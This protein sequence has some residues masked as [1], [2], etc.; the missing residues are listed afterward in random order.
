MTLK[1][2]V[3]PDL[4]INACLDDLAQALEAGHVILSASTGSGKT[5][6]VPISLLDQPWLAG[7]KII[8]LEP[9]RPAAR[10]AAHRMAY[11][12]GEKTGNTVGYQVRFDRQI[13][14][15]TRVEV[16]TEGLLLK[17]LQ[18]DPELSGVGLIIFDE[19]HERS[20]VAD[21][22]LALCID[23]C[24][25][26]RDDLRLLIMSATLD[27]AGLTQL[28]NA[29]TITAP[30]YLHPVTV[31]YARH[32]LPL[33][34]AVEACLPLVDQALDLVEADVLVFLPG[35]KEISQMQALAEEKWHSRCEIFSLYGDLSIE[36]QDQVLNPTHKK[37]RRLILAT[38]IAE[39]SLTIEGV[40]AVV[41]SGRVRK[42]LFQPTNGL[43]RLQMHWVSKA[44]ASQRTGRAGRLGPGLCFRAWTESFHQR[45]E[46][47]IVPEI[48]NADLA[49]TV[50]EVAAWGVNDPVQLN[51]FD[52]P[53]EAH[54]QQARDLLIRLDGIDRQGHITGQGREMSVLPVHPRLAHMLMQAVSKEDKQMVADIAALLTERDPL[55]RHP[56]S[57][58]SVDLTLRL[59][60]LTQWRQRQS[61][62][63]ADKKTLQ[64]LDR[65]SKQFLK[66]LPDK[67]NAHQDADLSVGAYLAMAYPDRVAKRR[68]NATDYLM[69]NGRGVLLPQD[70][71]LVTA[72]YLVIANLDAGKRDSRAWL[73]ATIKYCEIENLFEQQIQQQRIT[74]WDDH[75]QKVVARERSSLGQ[76]IL[77][78]HQVPLKKDDPVID[79]LLEQVSKQ[80]LCLFGDIGK[81]DSLRARIQTL[82]KLKS[83]G[84]WPDVSETGLLANLDTWLVPWLDNITSLKQLRQIDLVSVF[85]S[86]LGWEKRQRLNEL[87]PETYLTPAGT[88]RKI[89]YD[90][91]EQPVLSV[92][93]QEMLGIAD[94][95][96][97]AAGELPLVIHLLSPSGRPLQVTGDLA[98]FWQGAY[99]EVKKEM[100][101]RYPKHYWPDDPTSAQATRFT[102]RHLKK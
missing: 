88:Q 71:A 35:R 49:A 57:M 83:F 59:S 41:D 22:S 101:G 100:R 36:K 87:L 73:A 78:E 95:H 25:G 98:G 76:I 31:H 63:D 48:L 17:R 51:W 77:T 68:S 14:S 89:N 79:T 91:T 6:V 11:L 50:L 60:A 97:I 19:F 84:D 80:G 7:K 53:P 39:T 45:L 85:E 86:W 29:K 38:D 56:G 32:D 40:E 5:T 15:D 28:L 102:K 52:F 37:Q 20:L 4:P 13:S 47:F 1:H 58:P 3:P 16:L 27:T 33:N 44:S 65:L 24:H 69:T 74:Y 23:V 30:G 55:K 10:M 70:D 54:W 75:H 42:P 46:D 94:S 81:L 93:L 26:L 66:L 61:I 92:P 18:S 62:K 21:V 34:D 12:L 72:Q 2:F 43:T 99:Q 90:F 82:R 9:R 67:K 8:M 96:A 64:Q